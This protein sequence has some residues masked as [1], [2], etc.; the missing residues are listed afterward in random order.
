MPKK[1]L[2]IVK[3]TNNDAVIQ[4]KGNQKSLFNLAK[5]ITKNNKPLSTAITKNKGHGRIDT[6][7]TQVFEISELSKALDN[8]W[9]SISCIVKVSRVRNLFNTSKK[10]YNNPNTSESYYIATKIQDAKILSEI[11][12]G[13]WGIENKVNH[14]KDTQF[15]EDASRIREKPGIFSR[16]RGLALNLLRFNNIKNISQARFKNCCNIDYALNF[17]GVT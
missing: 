3:A 11:I 9:N 7:K 8:E 15:K 2:S 16:L 12:K 13:H 4:L 14:V 1:T 6:R 17:K 10:E 5:V